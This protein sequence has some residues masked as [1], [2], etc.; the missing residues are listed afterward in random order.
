MRRAIPDVSIYRLTK[1]SFQFPA[2]GHREDKNRQDEMK[3]TSAFQTHI[4]APAA[5]SRHGILLRFRAGQVLG[6]LRS[7]EDNEHLSKRSNAF[8]RGRRR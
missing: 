2:G 3:T 8:H 6:C 4:N 5:R 1:K 7:A